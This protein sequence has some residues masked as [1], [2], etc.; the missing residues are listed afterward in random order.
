MK[1]VM[2]HRPVQ[3]SRLV[4][5][6]NEGKLA[7]HLNPTLINISRRFLCNV[8][9]DERGRW[10]AEPWIYC[11]NWFN[12]TRGPTPEH[13]NRVWSWKNFHCFEGSWLW[14]LNLVEGATLCNSQKK[15]STYQQQFLLPFGI[16]VAMFRVS[17]INVTCVDTS[18]KTK[19]LVPEQ[20]LDKAKFLLS[21][22]FCQVKQSFSQRSY[23]EVDVYNQSESNQRFLSLLFPVLVVAWK[24]LCS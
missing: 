13:F 10:Q 23:K 8:S 7:P 5:G 21:P 2:R 4:K 6:Q 12:L 24:C 17:E 3:N 11:A 1:E 14:N 20:F 22:H 19:I 9:P 15:T 18:Q 16:C